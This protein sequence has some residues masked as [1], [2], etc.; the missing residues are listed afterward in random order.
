[1]PPSGPVNRL[2]CEIL[3]IVTPV[4]GCRRGLFAM[5]KSEVSGG[6]K[7]SRFDTPFFSKVPRNE[8]P[9]VF[10]PSGY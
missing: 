7:Q 10:R 4:I 3:L 2:D 9:Q 5:V 1:M 8:V 6:R